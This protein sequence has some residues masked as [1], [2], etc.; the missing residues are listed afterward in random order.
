MANTIGTNVLDVVNQADS[1]AA[2]AAKKKASEDL[3]SNF[4]T[5]LTTQLQNQDPTKPMENAEL[6][7][8]LAQINTVSGI[9]ELN[10]TMTAITGQISTGQ[11]LQAT[12]LVGKGVLIEGD[13]ILVGEEGVTTP[14]G[15][16]FAQGADNVNVTIKNSAGETVRT[17]ALGAVAAGVSDYQWDGKLTDGTDAPQGAY[18]FS[19]EASALGVSKTPTLLNYGLVSGV[20]KAADGSSLLDM[21]GTVG[22]VKLSDV[23]TFY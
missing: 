19:V 5:L 3:S 7:S 13:R 9:E 23:R 15:M 2:A 20:S 10:T 21:G 16:E 17:Y 11:S 1:A 18:T 4:M 14:F 22:Q 8:Q 12:L 6:T